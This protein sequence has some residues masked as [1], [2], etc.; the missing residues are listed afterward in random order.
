MSTFSF[1]RMPLA[2]SA[3]AGELQHTHCSEVHSMKL[4]FRTAA[5]FSKIMYS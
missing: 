3:S 4:C 1:M 2:L 5:F